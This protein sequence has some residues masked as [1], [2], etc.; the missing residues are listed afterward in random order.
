MPWHGST[1][2]RYEVPETLGFGKHVCGG[3]DYF[4]VIVHQRSTAQYTDSAKLAALCRGGLGLQFLVVGQCLV[5]LLAVEQDFSMHQQGF[6]RVWVVGI[7][8]QFPGMLQYRLVIL[9]LFAYDTQIVVG[10]Q[11]ESAFRGNFADSG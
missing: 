6:F 2:L 8:Q 1:E 9:L 5:V 10:I 3:V 11:A 4:R 7:F